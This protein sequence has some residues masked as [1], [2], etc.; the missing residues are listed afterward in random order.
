MAG[1]AP[2][3][4]S[5]GSDKMIKELI[6]IANELDE[7]GLSKESDALD[8]VIQKMAQSRV[9]YDFSLI[10]SSSSL[11]SQATLR[12]YGGDTG[13]VIEEVEFPMGPS[14]E[15]IPK[16]ESKVADWKSRYSLVSKKWLVQW[17][18]SP[19]PNLPLTEE[20]FVR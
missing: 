4:K 8:R 1:E 5:K 10:G 14:E 17:E 12:W 15:V 13:N 3:L 7:K 2:S 19:S 16:I 6:Q 11:G 9:S 20:D 18:G